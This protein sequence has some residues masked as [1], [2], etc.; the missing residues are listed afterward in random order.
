MVVN[1]S[2]SAPA[3]ASV[4][5]SIVIA[6]GA[7]SATFAVDA[8]GVGAASV[9]A[10]ATGYSDAVSVLTLNSSTA[11]R[12]A[13]IPTLT[14]ATSSSSIGVASASS[15][16]EVAPF[17]VFSAFDNNPTGRWVT[18]TTALGHSLKWSFVSPHTVTEF[19]YTTDNLL[20]TQL[21]YSDDDINWFGASAVYQE[22]QGNFV[23]PATT[24]ATPH[25]FWRLYVSQVYGATVANW[26]GYN[27]FQLYSDV[28]LAT[29]A[30]GSYSTQ[31]PYF[32][33]DG[34][35]ATGWNGG[36]FAPAWI[37]MD[38][39]VIR[40]ISE[41][42]VYAGTGLPAGITNYTIQVSDDAVTW[43]SVAQASGGAYWTNT[44]VTATGR[45][46]RL[47]INSHTGGSWIALLNSRCINQRCGNT[48]VTL[49]A[50]GPRIILANRAT[51]HSNR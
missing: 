28:P 17:G 8:I 4:P 24:G 48:A 18:N 30:S 10:S 45:F 29:T 49:Q 51:Q 43:T 19:E 46:V 40:P 38:L 26:Y 37:A 39:G 12:Y 3:I 25:R 1:L 36:S 47:Y 7:A 41:V 32:G 34:S 33:T 23:R 27:K 20:Y 9:T 14:S 21:Q 6:E 42:R 13:L 11:R 22:G 15:T 16:W 35:L 5:A 44:P 31:T 2:S 50:I